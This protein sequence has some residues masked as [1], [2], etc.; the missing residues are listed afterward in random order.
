MCQVLCRAQQYL[1]SCFQSWSSTAWDTEELCL[2]HGTRFCSWSSNFLN[3]T[4]GSLPFARIPVNCFV[5]REKR[6]N[7]GSELS[8][9]PA[10]YMQLC[11]HLQDELELIATGSLQVQKDQ[12]DAPLSGTKSLLCPRQDQCNLN[13]CTELPGVRGSPSR[14]VQRSQGPNPWMVKEHLR[15]PVV[16]LLQA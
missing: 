10:M 16:F 9:T 11:V 13:H 1:C 7:I 4:K 14:T 5:C 8:Y 2:T 15:F 6:K 3:Q 12:P